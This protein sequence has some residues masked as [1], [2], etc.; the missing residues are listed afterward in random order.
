MGHVDEGQRKDDEL[1]A[2]HDDDGEVDVHDGK[3]RHDS[4]EFSA[5]IAI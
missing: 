1:V 5:Y 3:G 2:N 4:G